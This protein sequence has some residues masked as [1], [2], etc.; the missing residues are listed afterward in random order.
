MSSVLIDPPTTAL[1]ADVGRLLGDKRPWSGTTANAVTSSL[2]DSPRHGIELDV[3]VLC[4]G[5]VLHDV[6][7]ASGGILGREDGAFAGAVGRLVFAP[8]RDRRSH[9]QPQ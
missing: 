9:G 4:L 6:G 3:E 1:A 8:P 2:L 5:T 7:L